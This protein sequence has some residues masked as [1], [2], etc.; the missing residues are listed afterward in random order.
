MPGV[1]N[2]SE[3]LKSNQLNN[4]APPQAEYYGNITIGTPP[5][6]FTVIFDTV[7][8][9]LWVPSKLCDPTDEAC[10]E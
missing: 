8:S 7:S 1:W 5:Q 10:R 3:I 9:N 6:E 4:G 2:S